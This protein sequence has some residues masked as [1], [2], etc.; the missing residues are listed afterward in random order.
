MSKT[1]KFNLIC[2]GY[3]V[4]NLEDLKENFLIEDILEYYHN[5]MLVKWLT[6]RG[7]DK[8]VE[9]VNNIREETNKDIIIELVKIFD[10]ESDEEKVRKCVYILDYINEKIRSIDAYRE[11]H[12]KIENIIK[13]YHYKYN[14]IIKD[15]FENKDDMAKIKANI[16]MIEEN[17]L[18]LFKLNYLE[19]YNLLIENAPLAIFAI[20][21]NESMREYFLNQD[22][23]IFEADKIHNQIVELVAN[24]YKLKVSLG[25]E[26]KIF[27]G[28]TE[29]Y[30]K[31]IEPKG[32]KCMI[33]S[34]EDGN[35]IKN[36]GVFGEELS[37]KDINGKFIIL[38]GIDYKS[39][40]TYKQLIYMEV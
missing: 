9:S 37:S 31:D 34:I 8:Y 3:P 15:I 35:Y 30:W 32:K 21:M 22:S 23:S 36:A 12:Y 26:L 33:L 39:N 28:D 16:C 24:K 17:Y 7:Y 11:G 29:A 10:I 19:L 4:R 18:E 5:G 40:S 13:D 2:N 14:K 25:K 1:I 27:R 6:V 38:D 20:L